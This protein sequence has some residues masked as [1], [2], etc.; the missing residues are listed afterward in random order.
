MNAVALVP[1]RTDPQQP[2]RD[3][4]WNHIRGKW[5][6]NGWRLVVGNNPEDEFDRA[7][8]INDA[9]A[10]AGDWEVAIISD[11]DC[12]LSDYRL[13]SEACHLAIDEYAYVV[14][15]NRLLDVTRRGTDAILRGRDPERARIKE[16]IAL[17]WCGMFAV[18]RAMWEETGG[19]DREFWGYGGEDLAFLVAC[20][21]IG[22]Q[23]RLD[24][25]LYH[26]W[27]G[28]VPGRKETDGYARNMAIVQEYRRHMGDPPRM[29]EFL[30]GRR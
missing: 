22:Q 23:L 25:A 21:T 14:P 28:W 4:I 9:A 17:V 30:K 26:L 16:V 1:F 20:G 8:S 2:R 5:E 7:A 29:R 27:H 24:G 12:L 15:H 3:A 6:E 10:K 11:A 18:P 13:A 19:F